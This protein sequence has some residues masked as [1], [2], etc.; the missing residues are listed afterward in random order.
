[1]S[2][3]T[4]RHRVPM[5]VMLI[6]LLAAPLICVYTTRA[7][8]GSA[9][10][11]PGNLVVSRSVYDNNPGNVQVGMTLP[12]SCTNGCV[13]AVVDGTYPFVWNNAPVD[14]SFGITSKI[15]LDQI[16]TSGTLINSL[17][18]PNSSQKGVPP[19]K[20]QMVTSFSS[21]SELA[22][23]LSTDGRFL[24]FMGYLAPINALDVSNSNTPAVVDP[25]NPVGESFH[26]VFAQIDQRGKLRFTKTN[27]YS[28]NNGRAAILNNT[29]GANVVYTSGNAGNGGNPQPDGIIIGAGAQI[30]T[31]EVKALVAQSPGLPTPVASFNITQLNE[32][33]DKIGKDTNFRGLTVF[34]NV[35]YY[36]KGSGGNGV[37]TVYF[38]DSTGAVCTNTSGVGLPVAGA[39]LPTSPLAYDP[40]PAVI[41]AKGLDPN[42]M[43]V[44]KGFPIATK[45]KTS[46]PFG[47]W[48]ANAS[49]LY[50]ADEGNGNTGSTV[51]TFYEPA[52]AQ[53]TAGL[54]KW[55][56]ISGQW[57]LAYT[58]SAGLDLGVPYIVAG[59]PAGNNSGT[60]GTGFPWA[61]ATAGLRNIT[62][63][64]NGDGTAT[65]Y[66]ITSTIS[67]NG[68][69]GADPNKLV[70]ITDTLGAS[71]PTPPSGESFA[72]LRTAGFGE[73]LRGVS[74]TPSR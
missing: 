64:V 67:G 62:G 69:Q 26:R 3:K 30:L 21:K 35:L 73:V 53:T 37:N 70:V 9:Y 29:Q 13:Q 63:V 55:V 43:C 60:G 22:L 58:L 12:P 34:D 57:Q 11:F 23:N 7:Q 48:F 24:T 18:V 10:F 74:F 41:Q 61:P 71:G 36:T 66:A 45:S 50:V 44:L 1:M 39:T 6:S 47:I 15:F 40:D 14:G 52:A 32:S 17:E 19:T 68:D 49:T 46:F 8:N 42:N 65:I 33:P 28:G 20:D 72:T 25:T 56:L 59:Y 27:A 31:P 16:S 54:Q 38:V 5:R 51:D 4:L 2:A